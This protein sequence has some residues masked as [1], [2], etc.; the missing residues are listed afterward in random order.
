MS[1]SERSVYTLQSFKSSVRGKTLNTTIYKGNICE[2]K[3]KNSSL[4]TKPLVDL[5]T[6]QIKELTPEDSKRE[7]RLQQQS[8]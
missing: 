7:H 3:L 2:S 6:E 4:A 5:I 1:Y 8:P